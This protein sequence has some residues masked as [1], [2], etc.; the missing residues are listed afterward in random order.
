[1]TIHSNEEFILD[2]IEHYEMLLKYTKQSVKRKRI[3]KELNWWKQELV[4]HKEMV[5][6]ERIIDEWNSIGTAPWIIKK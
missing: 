5:E 3:H 2:Y 1:M 4:R 6:R